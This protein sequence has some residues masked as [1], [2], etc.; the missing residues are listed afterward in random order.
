MVS[1]W[2]PEY[3]GEVKG[4]QE[5]AAKQGY[6]LITEDRES[7][8]S[9]RLNCG[10]KPRFILKMLDL[11]Q[12][13][14]LWVDIDARFRLPWSWPWLPGRACDFACWFIP[15]KVMRP[16][17]I[18]GGPKKK[19]DGLASGTMFFNNTSLAKDLLQV[20][21]DHDHGQYEYEQIVLGEAWYDRRHPE[22]ITQRLPQ[23]YC[24]VHDAPWFDGEPEPILIEHM[25]ASRRLR[26]LAD[27]GRK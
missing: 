11:A 1:F 5:S 13:P 12:A 17:D 20:W 6:S 22:L 21:I 4:F 2:T 14:V 19:R 26:A 9:W 10:I 27:R 18:P 23:S 8:G 15:R 3:I 7:L 25:Q 16:I 24:K